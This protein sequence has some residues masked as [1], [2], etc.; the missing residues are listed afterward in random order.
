LTSTYKAPTNMEPSSDMLAFR[1]V[2]ASAKR[3]VILAGAGLSA[4]SGISTYRGPGGLWMKQDPQKLAT[5]EAFQ[6][7]P[8]LIWQFYHYRRDI[9]LKAKPN[10]AHHT[11]A[12]LS[13]PSTRAWL[14]PSLLDPHQ[15][16]LFITQNFDSLS[17][18]A[19]EALTN[20]LSSEEMKVARER[21]I[22]MHGS[23]FRTTCLQCKHVNLTYDT[24]LAPALNNLSDN[25][26]EKVIPVH[27]LP[28]CGGPNWNGSNRFGRCGGLLR[29]GVVWFGEMPEGMGEIAKVLNWTDVLIVV[30]TS[31]LVYPAAGFA[32]TV[33][34]RGGKVAVFN[35]EKSQGDDEVDFLFL[36]ACEKT[37]P[38]LFD[39]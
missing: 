37:I 28:R 34:E 32:K 11:L 15:P 38:K 5:P 10:A 2:L 1:E 6:Q 3:L 8:S 17:P 22:E 23:A 24:P 27:E 21:L 29:P 30:G 36:G 33:K 9:C 18:R 14:L 35:L 39:I 13:L 7:D 20:Q 12:S 16:P 19:L 4:G 26:E 25:F 31:S